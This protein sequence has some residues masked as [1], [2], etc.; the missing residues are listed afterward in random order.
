MASASDGA[1]AAQC[2]KAAW[3]DMGGQTASGERSTGA[4]M[5]AA[6]RTLPFGTKVRVENLDN[7]RSVIVRVND[8][9][10]FVG[11]RVIDVTRAAAEELGMV[12]SGTAKVRVSVVDSK[13]KLDNTCADPSPRILT[14]EAVANDAARA[15][16]APAAKAAT[17]GES[18]PVEAKAAAATPSP[19]SAKPVATSGRT[20]VASV[21]YDEGAGT[22]PARA[23]ASGGDAAA[24]TDAP[25]LDEL[26]D[27]RIVEVAEADVDI[28][29]P[30]PRPAQFDDPRSVAVAAA[31]SPAVFNRTL[32]LRFLDAFAPPQPGMQLDVRALGYAPM[33]EPRGAIITE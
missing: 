19:N 12:R 5:T 31:T 6:H 18:E 2:G 23:K 27:A 7:G 32:A 15:K 22:A 33:P 1:L 4:G 25:Q 14:A 8:R 16:T 17:P 21:Q 28:P 11:G 9:G 24:F 3:Y 30:R 26:D 13:A 20:L 29:L 10:P